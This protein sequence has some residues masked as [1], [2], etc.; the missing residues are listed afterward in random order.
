MDTAAVVDTPE[1]VRVV[2]RPGLGRGT[3]G[4]SLLVAGNLHLKVKLI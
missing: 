1:G 2:G 4:D 3:A